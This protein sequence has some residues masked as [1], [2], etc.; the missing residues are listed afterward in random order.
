MTPEAKVENL[1]FGVTIFRLN[2]LDFWQ[3]RL[4]KEATSLGF[5]TIQRGATLTIW[6]EDEV[7]ELFYGWKF[8]RAWKVSRES[9]GKGQS[10]LGVKSVRLYFQRAS[11]IPTSLPEN[12]LSRVRYKVPERPEER[13]I[14]AKGFGRVFSSNMNGMSVEPLQFVTKTGLLGATKLVCGKRKSKVDLVQ[15]HGDVIGRN[16]FLKVPFDFEIILVSENEADPISDEYAGMLAS[17][18]EKFGEKGNVRRTSFK[19]LSKDLSSKSFSPDKYSGK[20]VLVALSGQKGDGL[21]DSEKGLLSD[22]EKNG[23][24][25]RMFSRLNR[26]LRFSCF[27]QVSDLVFV[28]GG[29]SYELELPWPRHLRENP[30]LLGVDLGHPLNGNSV[31]SVTLCDSAGNLIKGWRCDQSRDETARPE[32]LERLLGFVKFEMKKMTGKSNNPVLVLRDGR[33]HSGES[34]STYRSHLSSNLSFCDLSKRPNIHAFDENG[35]LPCSGT[36]YFPKSSATA[37]FI[38]SPP[39]FSGQLTNLQKVHFPKS[40]DGLGIGLESLVDILIGL[41]YSP[42]LGLKPHRSPGPIH[43]ADGFASISEKDCRFR[44]LGGADSNKKTVKLTSFRKPRTKISGEG[45][46]VFLGASGRS[47]GVEGWEDPY[48]PSCQALLPKRGK[49]SQR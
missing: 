13:I 4:S 41:S 19:N 35:S 45:V 3:D 12:V 14:H 2:S 34:I 15:K 39:A 26:Q 38:S 42:C 9:Y 47:T 22:L 24:G 21:L 27:N 7:R 10:G 40:W 23:I 37:Y 28:A 18:L 11:K 8:V 30:F 32:A 49:V 25:F 5:K 1:K 6:R 43:W 29:T 20:T 16:G 31:L 36:A 48:R 33:L 17:T 44:G 46:M